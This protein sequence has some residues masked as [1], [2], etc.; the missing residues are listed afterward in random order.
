MEQIWVV[1]L[2][3][4][5]AT[6]YSVWY[7]L[8]ASWRSRFGRNKGRLAKSGAC[9]VCQDCRGCASASLSNLGA[10]K[11]SEQPIRLHTRN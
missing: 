5:L 1:A 6:A 7:L 11:V 9:T 4:L 3:V 10:S 2:L 8:P